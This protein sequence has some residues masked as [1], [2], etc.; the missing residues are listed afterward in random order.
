MNVYAGPSSDRA[1]LWS[2]PD[3]S[4]QKCRISAGNGEAIGFPEWPERRDN[5]LLPEIRRGL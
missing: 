5:G 1:R 4:T 2:K 3:A